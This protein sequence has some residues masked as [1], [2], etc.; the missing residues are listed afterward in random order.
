METIHKEYITRDLANIVNRLR[1][2]VIQF[3]RRVNFLKQ[4]PYCVTRNVFRDVWTEV[5]AA[6]EHMRDLKL[7]TSSYNLDVRFV[8]NGLRGNLTQELAFDKKVM[9]NW[10]TYLKMEL[11]KDLRHPVFRKNS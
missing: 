1:P 11:Y 5:A 10:Q 9:E 7:T 8:R 4:N 6:C 3:K 2:A